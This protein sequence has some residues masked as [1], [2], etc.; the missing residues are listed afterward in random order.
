MACET[1][2]SRSRS[3]RS[4]GAILSAC[5]VDAVVGVS[6]GRVRGVLVVDAA[7]AECAGISKF[8]SIRAGLDGSSF[9]GASRG[10]TYAQ[11]VSPKHDIYGMCSQLREDWVY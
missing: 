8:P 11:M 5:R 1:A 6:V 3:C 10:A 4:S 2:S 7:C 9:G